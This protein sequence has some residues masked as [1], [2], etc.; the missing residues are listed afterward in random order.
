MKKLFFLTALL[1]ASV[2]SF[3][4]PVT[5]SSTEKSDGNDFVNGYDYS[6]ST[7]GTTVTISFTEKE[8]YVGLV[9]YLW[10]YTN[11]FAETP[12]TVSGHTATIALEDQT[13]GV[14]LRFACK[15]AYA[16][17][18]SVT[19]QFTYVVP[20]SGKTDPGLTVEVTEKTLDAATSE[21]F[22][23]EANQ[24]GDGVISYASSNED[25]AS[26]SSTGLITAVGRGTA[27]ITV[28]TEETENYAAASKKIT[29]IVNGPINWD[30]LPWVTGSND[31]FK[32]YAAEGQEVVSVQQP[33][34][35][36]ETGIYC[37]FKAGISSCSLGD[38]KYAVQGAGIVLY[39]SAFTAQV[40][41]VTVVDA[42][43]S[44]TFY[45][46]FVDGAEIPTAISHVADG[47]KA[48]KMIEDGKL[49]IIK[50]GVRYDAT[51]Q[52]IR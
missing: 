35:A 5:G 13:A 29:V 14:E 12:M 31:K 49:I 47:A 42:L 11:G 33:G 36:D 27:T 34:F 15:F 4:D 39:L 18:M 21:T 22:Q 45:V 40:T 46:Y 8:D 1:C 37:T 17:G 24:S 38:G 6:F 44:Y 48:I 51:G 7:S 23:I 20:A 25:I 52:V 10:N 2:M 43:G 28:S 41:E 16:G 3:A 30:A 9:A 26:V 50:N 32:V 19:K